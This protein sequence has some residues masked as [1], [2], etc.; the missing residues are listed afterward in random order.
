MDSAQDVAVPLARKDAASSATSPGRTLGQRVLTAL[1]GVPLVVALVY[2]GGPWLL[3]GVGVLIV[4]GLLEFYQMAGRAGHQPIWE[5]GL[6]AGVWLAVAAAWPAAWPARWVPFVL[7]ALLVYTI[8]TQLRRG[9]P[10][11]ALVNTGI[12]L[13]GVI[14]V[15]YLAAYVI[16]LRALPAAPGGAPSPIPALLVIC[17]VWAADS[18]AY[19]VGLTLGRHKL[20]PQVSPHKSREGAGAGV[21]AGV[22]TGVAFA[23]AAALPV[24]V[25]AAVGGLC[26]A[27]SIVGDLWESAIKRE[28]GVKDAGR[29]LPGHGGMLDRFD[30]LLFAAVA[31]YA[32]MRWW[33]GL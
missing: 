11:R 4:V 3:A 30:G 17:A 24:G 13:L 32:A 1:W 2:L 20:L 28:V 26:A 33:L 29:V 15:A 27:V 8:L 21:L 22:L 10:D 14:Y 19:F 12:T 25:A 6:T 7:P 5:A 16:R 9:H 23:W 18:T 31:G